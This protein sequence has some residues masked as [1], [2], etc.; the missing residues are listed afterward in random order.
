VSVESDDRFPLLGAFFRLDNVHLG[1]HSCRCLRNRKQPSKPIQGR[2]CKRAAS[3]PRAGTPEGHT[4][5]F[6]SEIE[7]TG[8]RPREE[9]SVSNL[10]HERI[11]S[12]NMETTSGPYM[13]VQPEL[14]PPG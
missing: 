12:E 1:F 9:L 11:T 6:D 2:G 3:I 10:V 5:G 4:H 8:L 13:A 14:T 7:I